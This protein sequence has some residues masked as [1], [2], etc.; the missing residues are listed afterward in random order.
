MDHFLKIKP[1]DCSCNKTVIAIDT[2]ETGLKKET[3]PAE[4]LFSRPRSKKPIYIKW[5]TKGFFTPPMAHAE[6][7]MG[8]WDDL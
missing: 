2:C 1:K 6:G 7:S 8:Q 3:M 5:S 4:T